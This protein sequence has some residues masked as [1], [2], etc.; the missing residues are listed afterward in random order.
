MFSDTIFLFLIKMNI[1]GMDTACFVT[2]ILELWANNGKFD[3]VSDKNIANLKL[4]DVIERVNGVTTSGLFLIDK[5]FLSTFGGTKIFDQKGR[6]LSATSASLQLIGKMNTTLALEEGVSFDDA[7]GELVDSQTSSYEVQL[8]SVLLEE[9]QML[10][11]EGTNLY[12]NVARSFG[13]ISN[14]AIITDIGLIVIG[15]SIVFTYVSLVLGKM[16]MIQNRVCHQPPLI[17]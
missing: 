12:I 6:L 4:E 17:F 16:S 14:N 13:D 5:D 10:K 1:S 8:I 3:E 15:F 9:A 7:L 11:S 2:S